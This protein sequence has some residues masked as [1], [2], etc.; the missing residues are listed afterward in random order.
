M[1]SPVELTADN[2]DDA[3]GEY[4]SRYILSEIGNKPSVFITVKSASF[5]RVSQYQKNAGSLDQKKQLREVC[6]LIADSVIDSRG[7]RIW[8]AEDVHKMTENSSTKRFME[9]QNAVIEHNGLSG[10]SGPVEKMVDEE[11]GN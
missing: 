10:G 2:R 4:T 6:E 9:L 7:N 11:L 3:F 8:N 5:F 1:S